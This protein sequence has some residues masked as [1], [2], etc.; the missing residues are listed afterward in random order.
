ML[1]AN[2]LRELKEELAAPLRA[3]QEYARRIANVSMDAKLPIVEE[4]YIQSF[5]VEFMVAVIQWRRGA[6]STETC[7][8]W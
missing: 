2:R 1:R 4:D 5:K 6:S 8:V 7:K 3:M